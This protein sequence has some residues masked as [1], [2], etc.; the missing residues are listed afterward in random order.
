MRRKQ[1]ASVCER[2][3]DAYAMLLAMQIIAKIQDESR[4]YHFWWR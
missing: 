1:L 2:M 3:S 4:F